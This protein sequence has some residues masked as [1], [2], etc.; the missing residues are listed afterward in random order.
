MSGISTSIMHKC[1]LCACTCVLYNYVV[2]SG[3]IQQQSKYIIV[4]AVVRKRLENQ[5]CR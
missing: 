5:K 4:L 1:V 3:I 2:T